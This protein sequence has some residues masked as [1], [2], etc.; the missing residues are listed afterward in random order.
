MV[1][2][3]VIDIPKVQG[4]AILNL[5]SYGGGNRF[6]GQLKLK[7]I[8]M[9]LKETNYNDKVLEVVGFENAVHLGSCVSRT[10]VPLKIA[11]GKVIIIMFKEDIAAQY[12]G[13][14][15]IQKKGEIKIS[16][17]EQVNMY[18]RNPFPF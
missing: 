17:H 3:T 2:G 9:G 18:C 1:D 4:I 16:L 15:Y 10:S 14:P 12:D 13:E 6:W 8:M 11:Q 5:P 7:E